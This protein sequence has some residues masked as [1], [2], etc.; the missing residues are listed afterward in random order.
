MLNAAEE[1]N[2][3]LENAIDMVL[4]KTAKQSDINIYKKQDCSNCGLLKTPCPYDRKCMQ[5]ISV[6]EVIGRNLDLEEIR[7]SHDVS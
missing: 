7:S 1:F 3:E 4:Q 5:E 6:D 2:K